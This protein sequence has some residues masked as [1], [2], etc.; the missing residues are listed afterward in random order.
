VAI[1]SDARRSRTITLPADDI[2]GFKRLNKNHG[3]IKL[4]KIGWVRF[5]GYRPLGGKLLSVTF[6]L[7]AGRWYASVARER[8]IADPPK[9]EFPTIGI[10]RGV[11]VFAALSDGSRL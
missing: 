10:D 5:R 3:A 2:R 11:A 4:P 6:R 1:R 9:S 8:E 7:K